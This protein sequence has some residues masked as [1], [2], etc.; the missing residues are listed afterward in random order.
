[1]FESLGLKEIQTYI[2]S[3]KVVFK[4][5]E[6]TNLAE[7]IEAKYGFIVPIL[8]KK[9]L[10]LSEILSKCPFSD[11]NREKSYIM[12][13]KE[14]PSHEDME[15]TAGFSHPNKE[16]QIVGNCV[17]IYYSEGAGKAKMEPNF[18]EKKL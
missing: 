14:T 7:A 16:F 12:L 11:E 1:M 2:Q 4:T 10:E 9:S 3:G 8:V 17:Y 6:E 15:L 13:L 18:F 5:M